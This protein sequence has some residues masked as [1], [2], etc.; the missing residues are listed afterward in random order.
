MQ[1]NYGEVVRVQANNYNY[2][3]TRQQE[4][5][6]NWEKGIAGN[7]HLDGHRILSGLS[8]DQP[9]L[10]HNTFWNTKIYM[11]ETIEEHYT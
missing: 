10:Q 6:Q 9:T 8:F 2:Y 5:S 1:S 3:K 7:M 11:G 4:Q